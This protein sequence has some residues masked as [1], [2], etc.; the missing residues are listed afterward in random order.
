MEVYLIGGNGERRETE[1]F[2][3]KDTAPNLE[4]KQKAFNAVQE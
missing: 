4:G 2:L 1:S 3:L